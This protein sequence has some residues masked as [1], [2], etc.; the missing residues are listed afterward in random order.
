MTDTPHPTLGDDDRGEPDEQRDEE[1][2]GVDAPEGV[3][4]RD[5]ATDASDLP[6]RDR[7]AN[8]E[9][10]QPEAELRADEDQGAP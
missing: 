8:A 6:A 9:K 7:G 3:V 4:T 1:H 5:H 2:D 10:V